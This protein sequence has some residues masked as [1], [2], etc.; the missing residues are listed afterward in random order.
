MDGWS[1]IKI[2]FTVERGILYHYTTSLEAGAFAPLLRI[3]DSSWKLVP[4]NNMSVSAVLRLGFLRVSR[5]PEDELLIRV[6]EPFVG[7][8]FS[9]LHMVLKPYLG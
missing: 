8:F 2:D 1:S 3:P 6:C 4:D 5:R 7:C 9:F